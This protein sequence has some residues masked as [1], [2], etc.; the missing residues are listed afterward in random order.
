M[1]QPFT[2]S[3]DVGLGNILL[4][5]DIDFTIGSEEYKNMFM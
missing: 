2:L 5:V 3:F 4:K 1:G